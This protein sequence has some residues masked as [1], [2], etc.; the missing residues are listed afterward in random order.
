MQDDP[1]VL[2]RGQWGLVRVG[3]GRGL[4]G[5]ACWVPEPAGFGS[6]SC[7][8]PDRAQPIVLIARSRAHGNVVAE[9]WAFASWLRWVRW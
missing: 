6:K 2:T 5:L 9:V 3:R 7:W 1:T 4:I 8:A